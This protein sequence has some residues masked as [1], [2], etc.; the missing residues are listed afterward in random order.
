MP[1]YVS[2]ET[3]DWHQLTHRTE[4]PAGIELLSDHRAAEIESDRKIVRARSYAGLAVTLGYDKLI[5]ATGAKPVIPDIS[6]IDLVHP[7]HTMSHA[8][9]VHE[10]IASGKIH[11]AA[12]VGVGYIGIEMA[13]ALTHRGIEVELVGR[14]DSVLPTVDPAIGGHIR[15]ELQK[16]GVRV[17]TGI[18]VDQVRR[19]N[20]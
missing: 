4:F 5:I 13:D 14:S 17:R 12:I 10:K 19:R 18:A 15:V 3:K 1:F 2:G 6:G 20:G 11:K 9:K 8:F 7:M 16:H